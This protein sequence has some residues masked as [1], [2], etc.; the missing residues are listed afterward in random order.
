MRAKYER[1][2]GDRAGR[3]ERRLWLNARRKTALPGVKNKELALT[4]SIE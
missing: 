1:M 3:E 4:S 2:M